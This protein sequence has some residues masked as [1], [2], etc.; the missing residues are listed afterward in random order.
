M[1]KKRSYSKKKVVL[2]TAATLG[3]GLV[4]TQAGNI[5]ATPTTTSSALTTVKQTDATVS[6]QESLDNATKNLANQALN[7]LKQNYQFSQINI[8]LADDQATSDLVTKLQGKAVS[9]LKDNGFLI[10][11][12]SVDGKK[13]LAIQGKDATGLFYAL[14]QLISDLNNKQDINNLDLYE[15]PQ[16]SIRGVIEGFYGKPWSDQARKDLF[17]F[18]GQHRMNTYIYSPKDDKYLREN[19]REAYPQDKLN[20]IKSLVDEANK[21]HVEFVYAL[22]PGNDITYSNEADYQ[23]TIKKFDQLRSIGVK[24][25][26]IA[27]DDIEIGRAHV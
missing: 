25:F 8:G 19:W 18:M 10:K 13:V 20:E 21:N 23:A 14:N 17:K 12:G 7:L 16:M 22:S 15:S 27:L 5:Y 24:Q 3:A 9:G 2:V 11:A 4:V 26:Y 6:I 1:Q